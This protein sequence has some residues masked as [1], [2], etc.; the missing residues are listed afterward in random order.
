[1]R[2]IDF[3]AARP[4]HDP[5][6][7][8]AI[9]GWVAIAFALPEEVAVMVTELHCTEPGCPP[10]ETVIAIMDRPGRPRMHKIHKG[11]AD[12]TESDVL[13]MAAPASR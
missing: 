4:A 12:V 3:L 2:M 6:R 1:M 13:T 5:D 7:I 11:I 10:L 8:A 9:K